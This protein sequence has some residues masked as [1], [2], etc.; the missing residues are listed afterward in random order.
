MWEPEK[1]KRWQSIPESEIGCLVALYVSE[2]SPVDL[3]K[4]MLT[5]M[6]TLPTNGTIQTIAEAKTDLGTPI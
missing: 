4:R 1:K 5:A 2:F 6:L 3:E